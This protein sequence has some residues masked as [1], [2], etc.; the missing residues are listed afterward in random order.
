ML[1]HDNNFINNYLYIFRLEEFAFRPN[2]M[3][4]W[5][6]MSEADIM[7]RYFDPIFV[8]VFEKSDLILR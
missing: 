7:I 3:N 6:E 2:S 5:K 1:L 4:N 8:A